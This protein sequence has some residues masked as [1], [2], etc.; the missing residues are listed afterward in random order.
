MFSIIL[1]HANDTTN[2]TTRPEATKDDHTRVRKLN[3]TEI[4]DILYG[5][6][7]AE[8]HPESHPASPPES[9][10]ALPPPSNSEEEGGSG[11]G[12]GSSSVFGWD[13]CSVDSDCKCNYNER[14]FR[15]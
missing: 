5:S 2:G 4:L 13:R 7:A 6:A 8:S 3:A 14:S 11:S 9:D 12:S 1:V 10:P 15:M